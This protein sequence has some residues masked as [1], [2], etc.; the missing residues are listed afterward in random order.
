MWT[1]LIVIRGMSR[2]GMMHAMAGN[3]PFEEENRAAWGMSM[4]AYE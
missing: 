3:W 1:G 2:S 4:C